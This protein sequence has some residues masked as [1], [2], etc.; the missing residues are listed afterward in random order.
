MKSDSSDWEIVGEQ[1]GSGSFGV[2]YRCK[3]SIQI[4]DVE[5]VSQGLIKLLKPT[6]YRQSY[7][8]E[9]ASFLEEIRALSNIESRFVA[10]LIDA[11]SSKE[12][13]WLVTE[14]VSGM[15]LQ[16]RLKET[17]KLEIKEWL[18]LADHTLR[19]LN[20]IHEA[21]FV[22]LDLKPSNIM[23]GMK[24]ESY[25]IVDL[26]I[27]KLQKKMSP[28][29]PRLIGAH[30]YM[31]PE[32]F[33]HS[34]NSAS[35]IFTLGTTLHQALFGFNLWHAIAARSGKAFETAQ[36]AAKWAV[37]QPVPGEFLGSHPIERILRS[38]LD[39]E[40]NSRPSARVCRKQIESQFNLA[41]HDLMKDV[42]ES[43][44]QNQLKASHIV[45]F[46]TWTVFES[47][48]TQLLSE[49]GTTLF[50]LDVQVTSQPD[51]KFSVRTQDGKRLLICSRAPNLAYFVELGWEI[52]SEREM[53][54]QLRADEPKYVAR[55]VREALETGYG[56]NL[57][58]M[59]VA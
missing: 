8:E 35:D 6:Q 38:M 11:G 56:L 58:D 5:I 41:S 53:R 43:T 37:N 9:F 25:V 40:P 46:E 23:Y 45:S 57:K 24:D 42:R 19:G 22:H 32:G 48:V 52:F 20:A 36:T 10:K 4:D 21:N 54:F 50:K 34:Y 17:R 33:D 3:K 26:G 28:V 16:E 59:H 7:K 15:N 31:P 12:Q 55:I 1:V 47:R 14:F 51:I 2:T 29:D 49:T 13:M 39:S 44:S 18:V 27:S 30:F